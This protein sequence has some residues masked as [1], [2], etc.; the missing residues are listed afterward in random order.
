M[1]HGSILGSF[2]FKIFINDLIFSITKSEVCNFADDNTLYSSIKNLDHIFNN[3]YY[4]L[5]KMLDWFKLNSLKGNPDK[6]QF[7]ILG[8]NKNKSFGVKVKGI[9]I[10]AKMK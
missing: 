8:A 4:E 5:N 1:P 10:P 3:L 9:H 2:L 6:F 7:K